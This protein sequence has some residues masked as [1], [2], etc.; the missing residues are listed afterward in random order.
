MAKEITENIIAKSNLS[1]EQARVA[2]VFYEL[3]SAGLRT[4]RWVENLSVT[5]HDALLQEA[6]EKI[7]GTLKTLA[8]T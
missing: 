1:S 6:Q 7:C 2:R 3:P 5:R 4:H 8:E